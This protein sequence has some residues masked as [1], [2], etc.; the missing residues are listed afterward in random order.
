MVRDFVAPEC[1]PLHHH[2]HKSQ[3]MRYAPVLLDFEEMLL[4]GSFMAFR[5]AVG[6]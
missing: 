4:D 6:Q 5:V 2:P 3:L 1:W